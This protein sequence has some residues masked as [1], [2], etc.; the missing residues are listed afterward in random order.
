M[1]IAIIGLGKMGGSMAYNPWCAYS[2]DYNCPIPPKE[3]RLL[4]PTR[5]GEKD[6]GH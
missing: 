2:P 3:N 1:D 6:F 5:A 4:V